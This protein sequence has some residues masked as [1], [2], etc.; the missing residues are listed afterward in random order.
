LNY[1]NS[2]K[3]ELPKFIIL[4]FFGGILGAWLLLQTPEKNFSKIIP[5]LM[6]ITTFIFIYGAK[7]NEQLGK[8]ASKNKHISSVGKIATP[9]LLLLVC[10]YGG[11]FN[12]GLGIICLSYLALCGY[13]N[14]NAM[15][16]LKLLLHLVSLS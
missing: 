4:S 7:I 12:A 2:Y 1:L 16:G 10:F 5:W 8:L 13:T 15:N 6:L 9:L 3:I 14:I 11:F